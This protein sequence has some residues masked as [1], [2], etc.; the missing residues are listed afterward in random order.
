MPFED[1]PIPRRRF[2]QFAT[3]ALAAGSAF[4]ELTSAR[5]ADAAPSGSALEAGR[6]AQGRFG[7]AAGETMSREKFFDTGKVKLNYLDYGSSAEP[8][9][10]LHG[11]AW[12][13]QEYLSLIPSLS[14]RW[15][16]YALDLRGN[17]RSGWAP[18][19][20]RL[21][22]F[23]D[24]T[25]AFVRQLNAPAVLVGHSIGGVIALMAAARCPEKVKALVIEDAPLTLDNYR[26]V[27][28]ASREMY[29][30]WLALK[31]S[32]QSEQE[33]AL[34]LADRYRDYPGV[35]SQ[36][37]LFF[38]RCLW[39]L[40]PTYFDTLLYDFD[41][42]IKGYDYK[43]VLARIGCP[44]MFIRGEARLGAVM[45]DDEIAWLQGNVR[46]ATCARIDAVGHLLHLQDQGQAP[47]LAEM[48]GFLARIPE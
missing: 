29:G 10:M 26:R 20:Y 22:D 1:A 19:H 35:T 43:R 30:L 3:T 41:G 37:I 47:V 8:L 23:T 4:P 33:L 9:V 45:T 13:W 7:A 48:T 18:G 16:I 14:Q 34:A 31:K 42:F 38:A 15:H 36:W 2:L 32:A 5:R 39:Q 25:V 40:D 11:G 21:E 17:G 28:D 24:D 44:V 27:I 46:T 6:Q 12:C